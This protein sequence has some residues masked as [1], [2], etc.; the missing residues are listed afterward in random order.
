MTQLSNPRIQSG[1]GIW[2]WDDADGAVHYFIVRRTLCRLWLTRKEG[3]HKWTPKDLCPDCVEILNGS[4]RG[5]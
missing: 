2:A 5:S 1:E 3:R 4:S